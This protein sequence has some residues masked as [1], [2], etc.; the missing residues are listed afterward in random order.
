M[1]ICVYI[2]VCI[3]VYIYIYI[4]MCIYREIEPYILST[5]LPP[6]LSNHEQMSCFFLWR[7]FGAWPRWQNRQ[8]VHKNHISRGSTQDASGKCEGSNFLVATKNCHVILVVT[9]ILAG[10]CEAPPKKKLH[11]GP[12]NVQLEV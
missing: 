2:Y 9:G 3:C 12:S 7:L 8:G 1:Y 6:N 10:G 4:H 5:S 11:P